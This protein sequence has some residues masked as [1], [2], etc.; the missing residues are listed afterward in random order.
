MLESNGRKGT[1]QFWSPTTQFK[2]QTR[3]SAGTAVGISPQIIS[4]EMGFCT[5]LN[6]NR[7]SEFMKARSS[8]NESC[9]EKFVTFIV[10]A[11]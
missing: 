2:L 7:T 8:P 10:L 6:I 1:M 9:F 11:P 5:N 4:V 3:L